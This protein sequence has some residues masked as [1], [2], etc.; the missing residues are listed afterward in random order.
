MIQRIQS[1]Y[2]LIAVILV[3]VLFFVPVAG[4]S[5]K[6]GNLFWVYLSGVVSE[7]TAN[8][9]IN[10]KSWPLLIYAC[11]VLVMLVWTIFRYG[12]RALQIRLSYISIL[13]LAG[14]TALIYYYVWNSQI[15]LGGIYSLKIYF[16]FP[17]VS[18]V[19][20]YLAIKGIAKDEKLIK[21]IDRIR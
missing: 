12:N 3:G 17:L 14:L 8:G 11:L 4:L 19:F 2:L 9:V 15:S 13:L 20:V 5:G 10:E 18:A 16:S 6:D 21:S 1:L 7:G